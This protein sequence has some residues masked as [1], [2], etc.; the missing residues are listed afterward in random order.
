M[1]IFHFKKPF[2]IISKNV[3]LNDFSSGFS[4]IP[5]NYNDLL[6]Y[7]K[8]YKVLNMFYNYTV[9]AISWEK[10]ITI[11][12]I[13]FENKDFMQIVPISNYENECAIV[14]CGFVSNSVVFIVD[15]KNNIKI[16]NIIFMEPGKYQ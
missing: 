8:D 2:Y 3:F 16:L 5:R 7:N 6:D 11:Y 15:I 10:I 4:F 14:R 9:F 12:A 13:V 1:R